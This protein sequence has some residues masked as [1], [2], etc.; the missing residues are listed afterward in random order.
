MVLH[1]KYIVLSDLYWG[2]MPIT[3]LLFVKVW[4]YITPHG[5]LKCTNHTHTDLNEYLH[6]LALWRAVKEIS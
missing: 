4:F 2:A 1:G 5:V 6:L 3:T